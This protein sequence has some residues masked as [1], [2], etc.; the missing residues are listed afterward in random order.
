MSQSPEARCRCGHSHGAHQQGW[1]FHS[2]AGSLWSCHAAGCTC[3]EF[4]TVEMWA[5]D[6]EREVDRAD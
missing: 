5:D 6:M 1:G 3:Q 2:A 4:G